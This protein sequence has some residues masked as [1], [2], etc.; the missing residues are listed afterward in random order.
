VLDFGVVSRQGPESVAPITG[1]GI[2]LGTPGYV[3]PELMT[4]AGA[5]DRRADIYAL[6]CVAFWLLTGQRPYEGSTAETAL[7]QRSDS[8]A[9]PP[10]TGATYPLPAGLDSLVL[11]SLSRDP[12]RRPETAEAFAAQLDALR[13]DG[14]WDGRRARDWWEQHEPDCVGS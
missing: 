11:D 8:L 6:G 1:A 12:A 13:M 5:F 2:V 3:A 14:R 7:Q 4:G 10:S 9:L